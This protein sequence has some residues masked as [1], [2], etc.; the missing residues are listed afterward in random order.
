MISL[1]ASSWVKPISAKSSFVQLLQSVSPL[2][3]QRL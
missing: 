2:R 3:K 1:K